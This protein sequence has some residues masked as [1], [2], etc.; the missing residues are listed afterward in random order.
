MCDTMGIYY[1]KKSEE[2]IGVPRT[3]VVD[4]YKSSRGAGN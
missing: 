2:G 4:S 3:V 1:L